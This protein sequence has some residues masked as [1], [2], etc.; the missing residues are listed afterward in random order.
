[1]VDPATRM[2]YGA[3]QCLGCADNLSESARRR[4]HLAMASVGDLDVVCTCADF[5][6]VAS[7]VLNA[8]DSS[9]QTEGSM[10]PQDPG[11]YHME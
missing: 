10:G 9:D 1:M 7:Y 8:A 4:F 2:N 11:A 6:Q 5:V 3:A